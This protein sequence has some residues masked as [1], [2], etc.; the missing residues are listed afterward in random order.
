MAVLNNVITSFWFIA[1][2]RLLV[3]FILA[4]I[5]G[6][7]RSSWNKPAG[8]KTH[9][10]V[11]ISA[12]IVMLCGEFMV[13]KYNIDPTRLA[14]QLL[15]GIGFIGAGTILREGFNVKGL[16]TAASLLAVTCVG[17]A[18]GAGFY[19]G[20]IAG[21]VIVYLIL[22][23]SYV[24]SDKVKHGGNI[25][26][27]IKTKRDTKMIVGEI[28]KLFEEYNISIKNI[29]SNQEEDE[30]DDE[31]QKSKK[32]KYEIYTINILGQYNSKFKKN[33]L[34]TK[35]ASLKGIKEVNEEHMDD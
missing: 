35:I 16:S 20:G 12:V 31:E 29:K 33:E 25:N 23:Y 6:L 21:T 34:I 7:E 10:L 26:I 27:E 17:L 1:L 2:V 19:V 11:C 9:S 4:A 18:V 8:F 22:S 13:M 32:D 14:A 24:L 15:S 3:G 30:N 5:I 28:D